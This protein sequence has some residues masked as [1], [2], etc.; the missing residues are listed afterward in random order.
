[1][2]WDERKLFQLLQIWGKQKILCRQKKHLNYLIQAGKLPDLKRGG[3]VIAAQATTTERC[4]ITV[5]QQA[6]WHFMIEDVWEELRSVNIPRPL[7]EQ[8]HKYF[9][10]NFDESCFLANGSE[11]RILG[12]GERPRHN[13]NT[14]DGRCSITCGRLGSAGGT[15]GPVI[16]LA[17]GQK[18][19]P[20]TFAGTKYVDKYGLPEGSCVLMNETA[21]MDYETWLKVVKRLAPAIW[22]MPYI[23]DHPD[24]WAFVTFDGFKLNVNVTEA[25]KEFHDNKIKAATE[26][27]GTSVLNQAYDQEQAKKDKSKARELLNCARQKINAV[28]NQWTLIGVLIVCIKNMSGAIWERSFKSVNLHPDFRVSFD[29]WIAKIKPYLSAGEQTYS[30]ANESSLFDA[31]PEFW[32]NMDAKDRRDVVR[33]TDKFAA[34]A[35]EGETPWSKKNV[36]TLLPYCSLDKILHLRACLMA[37]KRDPAVVDGRQLV[38]VE[39]DDCSDQ[40]LS[41]AVNSEGGKT[42][43]TDDLKEMKAVAKQETLV[44]FALKL[45]DLLVRDLKTNCDA[46]IKLL[47]HMVR[48]GKRA[49]WK[50]GIRQV[51]DYLMIDL[52][53]RQRRLLNPTVLDTMVGFI[54]QDAKGEG[55]NARL[56]QRRLNLIDGE[57]AAECSVLNS[58]E[59]LKLIKQANELAAVLA[60]IEVDRNEEKAAR[61]VAK[62]KEEA[63]EKARKE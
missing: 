52:D 36:L 12:D 56:P 33:M 50:K 35:G 27:G 59:R 41:S 21:Y 49:D 8:V 17:A 40:E 28:V 5:S 2:E 37:A 54:M 63:A 6:R 23:R 61:K 7:F 18:E 62:E 43:Q 16:F 25:L 11:L 39:D 51:S 14:S 1:M 44:T 32:K 46:Q 58:T 3:K 24:W 10:L 38:A 31:M 53:E 22:K 42:D 34:D 9:Q 47:N 19:P 29:D 55:A 15:K 30:R 48:F 60:D 20:R 57:I 26:E 13:K 4:Q 45:K